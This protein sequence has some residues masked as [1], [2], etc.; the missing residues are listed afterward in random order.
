MF[1]SFLLFRSYYTIFVA[2]KDRFGVLVDG[3]L[4]PGNEGWKIIPGSNPTI[5]YLQL[6]TSS[7]TT[8]VKVIHSSPGVKLSVTVFGYKAGDCAYGFPSPF[9]LVPY[10]SV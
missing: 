3:K 9:R 4:L 8:F 6:S 7:T 10:T 2:E 5:V 1:S